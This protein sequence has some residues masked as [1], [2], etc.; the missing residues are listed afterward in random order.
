ML[1][2]NKIKSGIATT[3]LIGAAMFYCTLITT[4]AQ[5]A[6][7]GLR[8]VITDASGAAL[9]GATVTAR[10]MATGVETKTTA[11]GEGVYSIPRILPGKYNVAV[12]AQGFKKTE[13]TDIE[14]SIGKDAVIDV[15]LETGAISEVVTVTGGNEALVEKDT[16]QISTTFQEKKIS[17]L[18]N[19]PGTGGGL[20]RLALLAP[21]VTPGF[22]NVNANGVQI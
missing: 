11:T 3:V 22:G 7:G 1:D 15:K 5:T 21:G 12:E 13:V 4:L 8:G 17:E 20:D 6:T 2:T 19:T 14:V 16:V 9:P 18:P 10:N